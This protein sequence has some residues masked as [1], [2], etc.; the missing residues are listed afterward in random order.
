MGR[1]YTIH[2]KY[3]QLKDGHNVPVSDYKKL[4]FSKMYKSQLFSIY[5][6][7]AQPENVRLVGNYLS[8]YNIFNKDQGLTRSF[9]ALKLRWLCY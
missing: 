6:I 3:I 4:C 9:L 1:K 2:G 8:V 5:C 7:F